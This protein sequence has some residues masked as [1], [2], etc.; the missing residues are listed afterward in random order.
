MADLNKLTKLEALK[1]LAE[2]I[3]KDF[4]TKTEVKTL[5]TRVETLETTGEKKIKLKRLK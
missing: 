2:R 4:S 5:E 1:Q 3:N